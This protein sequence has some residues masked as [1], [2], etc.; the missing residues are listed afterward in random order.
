MPAR[1]K[2]GVGFWEACGAEK[3][4]EGADGGHRRGSPMELYARLDPIVDQHTIDKWAHG[5]AG[6]LRVTVH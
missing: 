4:K 1:Y 5:M 2:L 6:D 3:P